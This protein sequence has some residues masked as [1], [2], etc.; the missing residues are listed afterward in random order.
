M[1]TRNLEKM[2]YLTNM[3][4]TL[5]KKIRLR[6]FLNRIFLNWG[7]CFFI[8]IVLSSCNR[9]V[10]YYPN[11]Y[12][13]AIGWR[14]TKDSAYVGKWTHFYSDDS[15]KI[16]RIGKYDKKGQKVGEWKYYDR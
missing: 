14:V 1:K 5:L 7:G 11:G 2:P 3:N 15:G 9:I 6:K 13:D 16:V 10:F 4:M 8:V 12:P